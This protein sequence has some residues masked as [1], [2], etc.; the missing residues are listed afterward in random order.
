MELPVIMSFWI[1]VALVAYPYAMY[2]LLLVTVN[3]LF[4]LRPDD[5]SEAGASTRPADRRD[6]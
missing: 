2:P 5:G 3:R 6:E 1:C 4:R